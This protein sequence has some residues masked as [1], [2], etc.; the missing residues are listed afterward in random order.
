[1]SVTSLSRGSFR[2]YLRSFIHIL[3]L[4]LVNFFIAP[5]VLSQFTTFNVY[6]GLYVTSFILSFGQASVAP[7]HAHY[8]VVVLQ[9]KKKGYRETSLCSY[10]VLYELLQYYLP[11]TPSCYLL[12]CR[13]FSAIL[14]LSVRRRHRSLH[15]PL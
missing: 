10:I 3:Q 9:N 5:I 11:S 7:Q 15:R 6:V 8:Y 14:L 13:Y 12:L 1:M 2:K 4:G